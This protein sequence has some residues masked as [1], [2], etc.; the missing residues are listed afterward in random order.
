MCFF[1]MHQML[2]P[3]SF[4]KIPISTW[5]AAFSTP[6]FFSGEELEHLVSPHRKGKLDRRS[7]TQP[8]CLGACVEMRAH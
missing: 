5:P 6:D 2:D 4:W 3:N 8:S 7:S 1:I